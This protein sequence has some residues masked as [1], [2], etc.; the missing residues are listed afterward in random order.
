MIGFSIMIREAIEAC[1][2]SIVHDLAALNGYGMMGI[3]SNWT[4]FIQS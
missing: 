2:Y 4:G 1:P 3:R